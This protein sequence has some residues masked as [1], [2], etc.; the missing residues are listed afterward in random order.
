M[1]EERLT[2]ICDKEARADVY[3]AENTEG[4]SRSFLKKLFDGGE[5]FVNGKAVRAS[6]KL[7]C[8]DEISFSLPEVKPLDV[9]PQNIPIDIVYE[10]SEILVINKARGMVVHPAAGNEDGTLVN[11][12]MYHCG[13]T[14]SG[15]NGVMRPGIV[16]RIDKDTT[17][18]LVV[19]KNDNAHQK[20]TDQLSDHTLSRVYYAIV[21]GNIKEDNLTIDA[22]IA[23]DSNDRKKMTIA[24]KDGRDALTHISVLERFGKYTFIKCRL[25][26][27]RTHQI[28]VH[29]KSIMHPILGDKTYGLKKEEFA[30][31]GQLLHAGEIGFIHPASGQLVSFKAPLPDDF[32]Q[33]LEKIRAKYSSEI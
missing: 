23:R 5:I 32:S 22:P 17:G 2:L 8:G 6:Y 28:R 7:K 33:T 31:E 18:L 29:T 24:K 1:S 25:K 3:I 27:G 16:H 26:T 13:D 19:A 14:L 20:L 10:D 11:A 12:L 4:I 9:T 30:L 21:H 15:I